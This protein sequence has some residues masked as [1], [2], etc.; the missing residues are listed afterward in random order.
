MV[1]DNGEHDDGWI[2][3]TEG[4]LDPDLTEEAGYL[5]WDPPPPGNNWFPFVTKVV[6]LIVVLALLGSVVLPALL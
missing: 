3:S 6:I 2:E 4:D 5:A 1:H